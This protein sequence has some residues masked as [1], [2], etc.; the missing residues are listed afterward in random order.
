[1]HKEVFDNTKSRV[2]KQLTVC[3]LRE[4]M[5][6]KQIPRDQNVGCRTSW[7]I[8]EEKDQYHFHLQSPHNTTTY[9]NLGELNKI[10][11]VG[12]IHITAN[13]KCIVHPKK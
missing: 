10:A 9:G 6:M 5:V 1:M 2:R 12:L 11:D 7:F 3:L 13:F 4:Q 8:C